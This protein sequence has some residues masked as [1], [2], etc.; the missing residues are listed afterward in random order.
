MPAVIPN[1]RREAVAQQVL[2]ATASVQ[3]AKAE[4]VAADTA[5]GTVLPIQWSIYYM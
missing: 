4:A 1:L 5:V 3:R 2:E